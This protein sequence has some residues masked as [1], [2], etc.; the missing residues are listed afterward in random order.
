[1]KVVNN[2][3]EDRNLELT[4]AAFDIFRNMY[5]ENLQLYGA[6][7]KLMLLTGTD[8]FELTLED[9][10][11]VKNE[12]SVHFTKANDDEEDKTA[13]IELIKHEY[14]PEPTKE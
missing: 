5:F 6:L 4:N 13:K 9:R 1:M 3:F 10:E 7:A 14:E 8:D 11:L 12:Y 2:K